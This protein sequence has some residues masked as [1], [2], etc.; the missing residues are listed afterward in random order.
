MPLN[1]QC[2][3]CESVGL[4]SQ[5]SACRQPLLQVELC[6]QSMTDKVSAAALMWK[7]LTMRNKA[8]LLQ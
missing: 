4:H 6:M 1:Q 5:L 3:G 7:K 2:Y 8:V